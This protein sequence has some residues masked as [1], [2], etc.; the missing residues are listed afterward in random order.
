[1]YNARINLHFKIWR[2]YY[3]GGVGV[4][5]VFESVLISLAQD[6]CNI[7]LERYNDKS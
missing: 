1:M 2:E 5:L 7:I 3:I 6:S 4:C